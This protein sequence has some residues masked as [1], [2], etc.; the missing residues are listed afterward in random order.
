MVPA[1][2]GFRSGTL[3]SDVGSVTP[4]TEAFT[5]GMVT[6]TGPS[7]ILACGVLTESLHCGALLVTWMTPVQ[8]RSAP[9]CS[10]ADDRGIE[11]FCRPGSNA[12]P[13][14]SQVIL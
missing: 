1:P 13:V 10:A 14:A 12:R 7:E 11:V 6:C 3:G 4:G 5:G 9:D 2:P 8:D